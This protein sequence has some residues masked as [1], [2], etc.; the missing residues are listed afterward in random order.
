MLRK[1]RTTSATA[2]LAIIADATRSKTT[3]APPL[4]HVDHLAHAERTRLELSLASAI[5]AVTV[6]ADE[7]RNVIVRA[8]RS[9]LEHK[10][11]L[12]HEAH[13]QNPHKAESSLELR[14]KSIP[15]PSL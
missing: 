2:A 5:R 7:Q 12:Q 9:A 13:E 4:C 10:V 1:L 8:V 6:L 3:Q 14:D 11:N 15:D